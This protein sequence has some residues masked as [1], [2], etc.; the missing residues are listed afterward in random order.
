MKRKQLLV[1][2]MLFVASTAVSI[3]IANAA[4]VVD[5]ILATIN[6]EHIFLSEFEKVAQSTIEQYKQVAPVSE[7]TDEKLK[8]L[9]Q[10]ILDQMIDEK[11][12]LQEAKKKKIKVGKRELE[13]G[14]K[15]IKSRFSTEEE[16]RKELIRENLTEVKF[17][18]RIE[19]QLMAMKLI[20]Q[21]VRAK[22]TPPAEDEVKALYDKIKLIIDGKE[23]PRNT[24]EQEKKDLTTLARIIKRNYSELVRARHILIRSSKDDPIKDQTAA[25]K[26]IEDI[27]KRLRSGEKG[28]DFSELAELY[29][30]DTG[31]AKR[32]GDL[33]YFARG[34]MVE[35]FEK[36]AFALPVGEVSEIVRTEFG[37]HLIKIDEKKAA[38]KI[39]YDELKNDLSDYLSGKKAEEEYT[40]WIK[41]LRQSTTIKIN[42]VGS[43]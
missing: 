2:E 26:K 8:E 27:Q 15:Q 30:E 36:A 38:R 22:L 9:R 18:E 41:N 24:T 19:Q 4:K 17:Q 25:K 32:G 42:P 14:I 1:L 34:D 40:R 37:Y 7:Q 20:D 23:L 39:S 11:L 43:E 35:E 31:S 21:E 12:I 3:G 33:G 5:K 16:F 13:Q 6:S 10:K 29:S 28:E